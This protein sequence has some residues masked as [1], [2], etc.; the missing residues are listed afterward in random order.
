MDTRSYARTPPLAPAP[1][2]FEPPSLIDDEVP[3]P[4]VAPTPSNAPDELELKLTQELKELK[5]E[6]DARERT[7][8]VSG[9]DGVGQIAAAVQVAGVH[10]ILP[11]VPHRR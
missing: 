1:A 4:A 10:A 2:E 3:Q 6:L 5:A 11:L 9:D 8:Q 7:L